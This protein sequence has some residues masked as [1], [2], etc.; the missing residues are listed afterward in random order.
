M[1][2]VVRLTRDEVGRL[3][4]VIEQVK[5]GRKV[6]VDG[7]EAMARAIEEMIA[8]LSPDEARDASQPS[9]SP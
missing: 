8:G 3:G 6:R 1:T 4:G 2:F 7:V 5:T 9:D